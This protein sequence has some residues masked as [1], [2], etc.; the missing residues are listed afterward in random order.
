MRSQSLEICTSNQ[1]LY[2]LAFNNYP[3]PR[4]KG[5]EKSFRKE[6]NEFP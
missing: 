5:A 1:K 3:L 6:L 2:D 4:V